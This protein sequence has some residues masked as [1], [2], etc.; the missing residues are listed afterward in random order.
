MKLREK[1][2]MFREFGFLP[3]FASMCS[4][5]IRRPM[6]ITRW[7]EKVIIDWLREHCGSVVEKYKSLSTAEISRGE[8]NSDGVI[9]SIWW[10]GEENAPEIVKMCFAGMNRHRGNHPLKIITQDNYRDYIDIPEHITLKVQEGIISLTH[11]SDMLRLYLLYHYGGLWLDATML[12]TEDIP[13]EIFAREY[14]SI[15]GG[16]N[17]DSHAVTMGR[18]TSF[19]QAAQKGNML[20]GF[21]LDMHYEYWKTYTMPIDYILIDYMFALAYEDFAE[22]RRMLDSV[23]VNNAGVDRLTPLLNDEWDSGKFADLRASAKFFKLTWKHKFQKS[24]S[25]RETMYGHLY[26]DLMSSARP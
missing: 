21:A 1:I 10:Q 20:C 9:W 2:Q 4:S 22:C 19:L 12:V 3:A 17:P 25:G 18:W 16:F 6:A 5:A 15:K 24:I 13:E 26:A 14:Y 23:P 7:K 11:F 8:V